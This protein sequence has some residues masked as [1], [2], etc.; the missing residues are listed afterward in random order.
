MFCLRRTFVPNIQSQ[1]KLCRCQ[2]MIFCHFKKES[3]SV[4]LAACK[5]VTIA[6]QIMKDTCPC[7]FC[8]AFSWVSVLSLKW[9]L[10]QNSLLYFIMFT[11]F[12][13]RNCN[14]ASTHTNAH[15]YCASKASTRGVT[16]WVKKM[17]I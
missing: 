4:I 12:N 10:P 5:S 17:E 2:D 8:Y 3:L 1:R 16:V 6:K 7:D 13:P 9:P 15:N 14:N 11:L